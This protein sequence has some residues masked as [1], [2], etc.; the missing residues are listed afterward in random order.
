MKGAVITLRWNFTGAKWELVESKSS[1]L[2]Q[3]S[4]PQRHVAIKSRKDYGSKKFHIKPPKY[5]KIKFSQRQINNK[6]VSSSSLKIL[7]KKL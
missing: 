7:C 5:W 2:H 3:P 6:V 4:K 1:D